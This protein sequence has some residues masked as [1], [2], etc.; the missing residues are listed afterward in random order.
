[1]KT[2]VIFNT[3]KNKS[4]KIAGTLQ[5]TVYL[6]TELR[7]D[8]SVIVQHQP[9]N[10]MVDVIWYSLFV[11]YCVLDRVWRCVCMGRRQ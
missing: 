10:T 11:L 7:T 5:L 3:V 2:N 8:L 9:M 1:M 6:L 4:N